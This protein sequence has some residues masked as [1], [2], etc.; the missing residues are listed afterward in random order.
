[1]VNTERGRRQGKKLSNGDGRKHSLV[2]N[3]IAGPMEVNYLLVREAVVE[4]EPILPSVL[5]CHIYSR[6]KYFLWQCITARV[7]I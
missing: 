5:I 2:I 3:K 7:T 1:M 4:A 6:P